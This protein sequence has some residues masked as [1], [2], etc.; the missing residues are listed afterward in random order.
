MAPCHIFDEP[1]QTW[2][3]GVKR[4][5]ELSIAYDTA[6]TTSLKIR[7]AMGE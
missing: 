5:Q 4:K 6:W 1:R 2:L 3:L 7:H